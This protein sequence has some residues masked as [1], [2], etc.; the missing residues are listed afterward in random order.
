LSSKVEVAD[1]LRGE[2]SNDKQVNIVSGE[3]PCTYCQA[4]S[5]PDQLEWESTMEDELNSIS[6]VQLGTYK[7]VELSANQEAINTK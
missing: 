7:L 1:A 4:I 2:V 5:S 3:E 6:Q